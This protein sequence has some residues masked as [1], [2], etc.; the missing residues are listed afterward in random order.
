MQRL[1]APLLA[2]T[3]LVAQA[4]RQ[5]LPE[6]AAKVVLLEKLCQFVEW[7]SAAG[8]GGAE[9]PFVLGVVGQNPFGDELDTYFLARRVK[10]RPVRIRYFRGASDL[11]DC[12]L[13]FVAATERRALGDI[14][15]RAGQKPTLT[16]SDGEGFAARG[17]MVNIT[18]NEAR[19]GF[20]VNLAAARS[21]SIVISSSLLKIAKV[22]Q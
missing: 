17:V 2:G 6:Y 9:A 10:G 15:A 4:P 13:L 20:E 12:D 3:F 14:L 11:G 7:P 21:A 8:A 18:R 5:P 19:L 16:V 1:C 22:I